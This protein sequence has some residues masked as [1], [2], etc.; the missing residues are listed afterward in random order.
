[1]H[2]VKNILGVLCLFLATGL[3]AQ[4]QSIFDLF[5]DDHRKAANLFQKREYSRSLAYYQ[6]LFAKDST[7]LFYQL[8]LAE[9]NR[10]LGRTLESEHW[11][12]KVIGNPNIIEPQHKLHYAEV[13]MSNG[14]SDSAMVWYEKYAQH[15]N[16]NRSKRMLEQNA[17]LDKLYRDSLAFTVSEVT[18]NSGDADFSP[19]YYKKGIVFLSGRKSPAYVQHVNSVDNSNFFDLY[20]TEPLG[21]EY[22]VPVKFHNDFSSTLH[23]GPIT[24]F[25][26]GKK[27][28]FS[29][30]VR[31]GGKDGFK[32]L[33]LFYGE[34]SKDKEEWVNILMLP[35][36][37]S[38]H[39]F[40][41]PYFHAASNTLYFI[42]DM[43]GGQGGTDIYRSVYS[44]G[45]WSAPENLGKRVNTDENELFPFLSKDTVLYFSSHGHGGLGGLDILR[46]NLKRESPEVE[47]LGYPVNS[48]QDDFSFILDEKGAEGYFSS[49]R[50]YGGKNDD[51]YKVKVN[52]VR[53]EGIVVDLLKSNGVKDA[54]ISVID[55]ES[56]ELAHSTYSVAKGYFD[57]SIIPG[58][59]YSV[60]VVAEGYRLNEQEIFTDQPDQKLMRI[61]HAMEK[62]KRTFVNGRVMLDG[63]PA[64]VSMIYVFDPTADTVD[65]LSTD[66]SGSFQCQVNADTTNIIMA[67]GKGRL[68]IYHAVPVKRKRK[69]S[70]I[71]FI[72]IS[73]GSLD[74]V[75]V[76]GIIKL[77][78]RE[79]TD[80][81][82]FVIIQNDWTNKDEILGCD[83]KGRFNITL[84]N[85]CP[86][87]IYVLR[88]EERKLIYRFEPF[89]ERKLELVE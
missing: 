48:P 14:K 88:N 53:V 79:P 85:T 7:E 28:V 80:S 58:R 10:Y 54:M 83:E 67:Q 2:I 15:K 45:Q 27:S 60:Q 63:E 73:L 76:S 24:F 72:E 44:E 31:S 19:M 26:K 66:A 71:Q 21:G 13:L 77:R 40:S 68:G 3:S 8:R 42:S 22:S 57:F 74:S 59:K 82:L 65:I 1:M 20:Y 38:S 34:L 62:Y 30:N 29:K 18:F 87:S 12:R 61:K 89:K 56:G 75:E 6:R 4:D 55:L 81:V 16:D 46:V 52:R 23:E 70:S 69:A 41:H 11:F 36:C 5:K 32:K 43:P 86:Y 47:N 78:K 64:G 84:W 49:N 9:C 39:N 25:D 17:E 51:I 37:K 50:K 33:K 35:F